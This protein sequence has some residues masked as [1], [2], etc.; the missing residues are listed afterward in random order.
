MSAA[1]KENASLRFSWLYAC[2][3]A[4]SK[5]CQQLVKRMQACNSVGYTHSHAFITYSRAACCACEDTV[6]NAAR[7]NE[8]E[9]TLKREVQASRETIARERFWQMRPDGSLSDSYPVSSARISLSLAF[10]PP[11]E[12]KAGVFCILE[13][14]RMSDVTD[15]YLLR[16]RLRAKNQY[17]S[18]PKAL[19]NTIQGQ[20][21]MV[22]QVSFM[23]G[24]RYPNE[25]DLRKNI[26]FLQVPEAS[27]EPIRSKLAMRI[28]DEY[29]C[30][31]VHKYP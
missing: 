8:M 30:T 26:K 28:F 20:G 27:I 3:S 11:T 19:S 17:E 4:A 5:A 15:Q 10:R 6:W 18:L 1:S 22:E 24:A 23:T 16:S 25:E 31:Q 9:R 21:W 12:S 7:D 29:S 14:K 13:F 2:M